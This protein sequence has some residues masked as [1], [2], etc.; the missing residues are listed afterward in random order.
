MINRLRGDGMG[1]WS[2][3]RQRDV[4]GGFEHRG[5]LHRDG[6]VA[7]GLHIR[8]AG[9][10][11]HVTQHEGDGFLLDGGRAA[12]KGGGRL[13]RG[14][15]RDVAAGQCAGHIDAGVGIGQADKSRPAVGLGGCE[16]DVACRVGRAALVDD[17]RI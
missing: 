13:D 9:G 15:Q 12:A 8:E 17:R 7:L 16:R 3:C 11:R 5:G 2:Q 10:E 4:F 1:S 14:R 6:G